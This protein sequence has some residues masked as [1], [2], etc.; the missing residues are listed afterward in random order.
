MLKFWNG[1]FYSSVLSSCSLVAGGNAEFLVLLAF[2][3]NNL[4]LPLP[5]WNGGF[6]IIQLETLAHPCVFSLSY[7]L[8]LLQSAVFSPIGEKVLGTH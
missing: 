6:F 1:E 4:T 5:P 3:T 8:C 7:Q 2:A